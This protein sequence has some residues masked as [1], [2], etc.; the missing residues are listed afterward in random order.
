MGPHEEKLPPEPGKLPRDACMRQQSSWT[1]VKP[2][3]MVAA[4]R[5][6]ASTVSGT[7]GGVT[8]DMMM[9]SVSS[10]S[11]VK[12][13]VTQSRFLQGVQTL[14]T[15]PDIQLVMASGDHLPMKGYK[16]APV[17]VGKHSYTHS[18]IVLNDLVAPVIL[19]TDFLQ[20]NALVL[21]FTSQPLTVYHSDLKTPSVSD[22]VCM[23]GMAESNTP[24]V[25]DQSTIPLLA[26]MEE[27]E[28]PDDCASGLTQV[29]ANNKDLFVTMPGVTN[30]SCHSISTI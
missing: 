10:V 7:W 26:G 3:V 19:G 4:V 20:K 14:H 28:L 1:M 17:T 2:Q 24:G 25:T 30:E 12:C 22:K 5:T 13:S 23:V 18:F 6:D 15:I 21:D 8:V 29:I 9:D 16:Q 27:I 11:L